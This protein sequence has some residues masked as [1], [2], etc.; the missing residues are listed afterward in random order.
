MQ[1]YNNFLDYRWFPNVLSYRESYNY[2][3][4]SSNSVESLPTTRFTYANKMNKTVMVET[5]IQ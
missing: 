3:T 5:T 2:K 4:T 1:L